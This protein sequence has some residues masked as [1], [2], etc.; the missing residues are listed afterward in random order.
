MARASHQTDA[1]S[2]HPVIT[3][4]CFPNAKK[5]Y[6]KETSRSD[7]KWGISKFLLYI[8]R[9]LER[10]SIPSP[11]LLDHILKPK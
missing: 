5:T 1:F 2:F 7:S 4:Q 9:N 8:N 10:I 6:Q 11:S 3:C